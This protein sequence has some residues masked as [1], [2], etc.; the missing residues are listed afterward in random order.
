[1][2]RPGYVSEIFVSF[3][4]EGAHMGY[5]HLFVRLAG[6]NLRCR[7]C[8]TPE[9]LERTTTYT[10]A[11]NGG[12]PEAARNPVSAP[13]LA[14]LIAQLLKREAPIDALALTG[15]EPLVQSQFLR[16]LLQMGRFGVPVL[17]E[18]NG[19]LPERLREVLPLVSI[20]SMDIKLSSNTGEGPFWDEH[21]EFLKLAR[22]KDLYVKILVDRTTVDAE[23][24][25]AATLLSSIAPGVPAFMQPIVDAAGTQL[26]DGVPLMRLYLVARRHLASIRVLPQTHKQLGVR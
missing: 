7:Y 22:T 13:D 23:V 19:V 8:D 5:R 12:P 18:T 1:M 16:A 4:G 11:A 10:V 24:A 20:I 26:I 2:V 15:G 25:H 6:C 9:S 3:Q 14:N 21:T 17:L